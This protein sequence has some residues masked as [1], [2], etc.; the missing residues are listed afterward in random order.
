[1]ETDFP[2]PASV[3][4]RTLEL[5]GGR[6]E[7]WKTIESEYSSMTSRWEQDVVAIG[8][9]LRSHLYVEHYLTEYLVKRNPNLG[10]LAGA[11]LTFSQKVELMDGSNPRL[12]EI[13]P[14]IRQLNKIRNR[15]A[16][17]LAAAV[18]EKDAAIFL[19]AKFFAAMREEGAKPGAPS[20]DPLDVLEK[21]AQ[22]ASSQL[23]SEFSAFSK[24]FAAA[25]EDCSKKNAT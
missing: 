19:Q 17:N 24:A 4:A 16:H 11:K 25:L 2:D 6:N 10:P 20:S 5:L 21:F 12:S 14:G 3:A 9:I 15:L 18:D 7:A 23:H 13:L 22:Y 8:R 1:M